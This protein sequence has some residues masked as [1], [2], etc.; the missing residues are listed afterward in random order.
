MATELL[1]K[2]FVSPA[3]WE[4]WLD[5]NH[6]ASPGLWLKI[7]KL[8][9]TRT[10]VTYKQALE[11][12]LLFGWI[13]GQK[14]ALDEDAWLQK[15]TPRG[16]R[17]R[18]SEVNRT[19]ALRLVEEGRMRPAGL[20]AIDSAKADG[21]WEAAYASQSRATVPADLQAALDAAP[22]AKKFFATLESHNRYAVLYR[23]QDAKKP[24]TRAKRI[25]TYVAMLAKGETL[26]PARKASKP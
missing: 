9:A 15:F 7:A 22:A 25:A 21:R 5:A 2:T 3:A 18:W 4:K 6:A 26:H 1:T 20:A 8:G 19:S 17:S 11:V 23:V 12:A 16:P 13:D 14:R 10:S 24:E